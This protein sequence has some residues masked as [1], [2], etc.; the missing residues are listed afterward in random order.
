M[1]NSGKRYLNGVRK[2]IQDVA[3]QLLGIQ[4]FDINSWITERSPKDLPQQTDGC[5]CGVFL[6]AFANLL[7]DDIPLDRFH[8]NYVNDF[9]RKL[10]LDI[11]N[12]KFTYNLEI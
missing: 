2:W 11:L 7:T 6:C 3:E 5:S 1:G 12:T 9:R 8:A 4:N 10:C